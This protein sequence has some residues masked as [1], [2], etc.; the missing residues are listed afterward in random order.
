MSRA[1]V[2]SYAAAT[3]ATWA[4]ETGIALVDD[5]EDGIG[6]QIDLV[7]TALGGDTSQA[8]AMQALT[9]YHVLRRMQSVVS[10][11]ADFDAT[12]IK[13]GRAQL[14]LHLK[15][16]I[17][18]AAARCAAAGYPV[19]GSATSAAPVYWTTDWIEPEPAA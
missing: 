17:A 15:D 16:M 10:A 14:F 1:T 4:A 7:E 6:Y 18:D 13:A 8:A 9:D 3:W 2:T 12:A 11:R 5:Y 19:S